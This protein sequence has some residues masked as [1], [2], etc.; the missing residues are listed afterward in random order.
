LVIY[1]DFVV[2]LMHFAQLYCVNLSFGYMFSTPFGSV[3]TVLLITRQDSGIK[4]QQNLIVRKGPMLVI[5][6][7]VSLSPSLLSRF[8]HLCLA[9]P[10]LWWDKDETM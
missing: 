6:G 3:P 9:R 5:S 1:I 4:T 7:N 8:P 10:F 2:L